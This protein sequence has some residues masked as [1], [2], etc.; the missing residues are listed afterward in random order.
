MTWCFVIWVVFFLKRLEEST[1]VN[2]KKIYMIKFYQHI[3]LRDQSIEEH[4]CR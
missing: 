3:K 2:W 1:G 4:P